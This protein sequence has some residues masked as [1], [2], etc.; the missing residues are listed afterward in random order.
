[1]WSLCATGHCHQPDG[2][3]PS[4]G[5]PPQAEPCGCTPCPAALPAF[6]SLYRG[7][8][9]GLW[10]PRQPEPLVCRHHGSV[11]MASCRLSQLL[12]GGTASP[13]HVLRRWGD[14]QGGFVLEQ[15]QTVQVGG[16]AGEAQV[17][18]QGKCGA[19]GSSCLLRAWGS[20]RAAR[21]RAA[22]ETARTS[23]ATGPF[24][25]ATDSASKAVSKPS[26][27]I[28]HRR[29]KGRLIPTSPPRCR[30]PCHLL[31]KTRRWEQTGAR[32]SS[33]AAFPSPPSLAF[34]LSQP[35]QPVPNAQVLIELLPPELLR[36]WGLEHLQMP[37]AV[38]A[39]PARPF[40]ALPPG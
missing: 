6:P 10:S 14:P 33:P 38:R 18:I 1:M 3:A 4:Q 20:G 31:E 22:G 29:R 28:R 37:R 32:R 16:G 15:M 12:A 9:R 39:V 11:S 24:G 2:M 36:L 25:G 40:P 27:R 23:S 13:V 19:E 34:L 21:R 17:S 30:E 7:G 26:P 8:L 5:F 35:A